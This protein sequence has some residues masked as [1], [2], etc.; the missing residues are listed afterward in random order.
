MTRRAALQSA[1]AALVLKHSSVVVNVS[2]NTG[3]VVLQE[4]RAAVN[5]TLKSSSTTCTPM[6]LQ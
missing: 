4:A 5:G 6:D 1:G 3:I 2:G